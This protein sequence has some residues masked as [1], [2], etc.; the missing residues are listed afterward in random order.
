[1]RLLVIRILGDHTELVPQGKVVFCKI[2]DKLVAGTKIMSI[3][4]IFGFIRLCWFYK[5]ELVRFG[6]GLE[7][8]KLCLSYYGMCEIRIMV[9]KRKMC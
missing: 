5:A 3:W 7:T 4:L 8:F 1:M 2:T 6:M 9:N